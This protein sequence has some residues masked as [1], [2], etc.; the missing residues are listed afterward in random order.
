MSVE[1]RHTLA[2]LLALFAIVAGALPAAAVATS[3]GGSRSHDE[4]AN[5][6][7]GVD[8]LVLRPVGFVSLAV[9]AGLFLISAPFTLITR[10]LEIGKP[11]KQFVVRPAKY[12]W[13]D[14]LGGH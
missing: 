10:P 2:A 14:P 4:A 13:A 6:P 1:I 5:A 11:F 7:L 12:L 8:I 9:G 3:N